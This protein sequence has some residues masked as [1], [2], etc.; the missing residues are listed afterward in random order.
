MERLCGPAENSPEAAV[1]VNGLLGAINFTP[2]NHTA[3][4]IE[5]IALASVSS[6]KDPKSM[7][8]R[9]CVACRRSWES[10]CQES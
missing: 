10:S 4:G 8:R 2:E 1:F 3:I 9:K 6:G 5:D 7:G